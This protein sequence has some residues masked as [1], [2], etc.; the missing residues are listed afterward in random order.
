ME[1]GGDTSSYV[2]RTPENTAIF[3]D[4]GTGIMNALKELDDPA[5]KVILAISHSHA[6]HVQGL[7]MPDED[8]RNPL[9]WMEFTPGYQGFKTNIIGPKGIEKGIRGYYDAKHVWPVPPEWMNSLD[10]E[11]LTEATNHSTIQIDSKTQMRTM[12]GNH[13]VDGGV[14]LYRIDMQTDNGP[15]S[16]GYATDHEFDYTAANTPNPNAQQLKTD[17][18]TFFQGVDILLADAQYSTAQY[19]TGTPKDVRGFGHSHPEQIIQLA[20][21]ANIKHVLLT[22]HDRWNDQRLREKD[23]QSQTFGR[24]HGLHAKLAKQEMRINLETIDF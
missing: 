11:T 2:I 8:L 15:V 24:K 12:Y 10:L 13:P 4:A 14:V 6:D 17:Y 20:N 16:F 18:T 7:A 1:Y 23:E 19:T 5:S 22:H 21:Q 3:F 9:P